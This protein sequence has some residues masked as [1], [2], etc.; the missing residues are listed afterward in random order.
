MKRKRLRPN[1]IEDSE[2]DDED[3]NLNEG[4][5]DEDG[6]GDEEDSYPDTEE[7]T[8]S[9]GRFW[10]INGV[11]QSYVRQKFPKMYLYI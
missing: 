5:E 4:Y 1:Q 7:D 9:D 11:V 8:Y 2:F 10:K 3:E 6:D